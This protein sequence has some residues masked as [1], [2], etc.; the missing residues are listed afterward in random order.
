MCI[1]TTLEF[2]INMARRWES[3]SQNSKDSTGTTTSS[4]TTEVFKQHPFD[5]GWRKN[6]KRVFGDVSWYI[7]LFPN[8]TPPAQ[9]LYAFNYTEF[10]TGHA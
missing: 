6:L 7:H 3:Y 2:Y 9:P 8:R 4:T 5:E 10:S 1:Q